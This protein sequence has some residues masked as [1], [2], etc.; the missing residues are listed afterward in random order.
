[1]ANQVHFLGTVWE[2]QVHEVDGKLIY[3]IPVESG[4][5]SRDFEFEIEAIDLE[6]LKNDIRRYATLYYALHTLL[7]NTFGIGQKP[8]EFSQDEFYKVVSSVLHTTDESLQ[9]F[10]ESFSKSHHISLQVYIDQYLEKH[11]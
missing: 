9:S 4:V 3:S 2:P 1:M 10:I 6:V 5:V 7:Q 11:R 8:K